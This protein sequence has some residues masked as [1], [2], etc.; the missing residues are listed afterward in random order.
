MQTKHT[1]LPLFALESME[2]ISNI[3]LSLSLY[4]LQRCRYSDRQPWQQRHRE[5]AGE[6]EEG[7]PWEEGTQPQRTGQPE[8]G[9]EGVGAKLQ[10]LVGREAGGQPR[11]VLCVRACVLVCPCAL[12]W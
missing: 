7:V 8:R 5:G 12:F 3:S 1:P 10:A 11:G 6:A 2:M 9:G 4:S